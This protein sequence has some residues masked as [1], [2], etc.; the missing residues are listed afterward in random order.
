MLADATLY[1]G[2]EVGLCGQI[3][4]A[5][6]GFIAVAV[7]RALAPNIWDDGGRKVPRSELRCDRANQ[8]SATNLRLF[9]RAKF[10]RC[11]EVCAG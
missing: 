1:F 9:E 5:G 2:N 6:I 11:A 8:R 4:D 7:R 3:A 10:R